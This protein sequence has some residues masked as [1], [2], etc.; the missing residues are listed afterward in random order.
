MKIHFHYYILEM[1]VMLQLKICF[2]V[3]DYDTLNLFENEF[4]DFSKS[5]YDIDNLTKIR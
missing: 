5:I 4:L 3:F 1:R 2:S